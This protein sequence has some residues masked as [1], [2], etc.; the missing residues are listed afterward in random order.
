M[1]L[2]FKWD[3]LTAFDLSTVVIYCLSHTPFFS[4]YAKSRILN[5]SIILK[6]A[7]LIMV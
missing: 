2:T 6:N 5:F 7:T 3:A 1:L 4:S